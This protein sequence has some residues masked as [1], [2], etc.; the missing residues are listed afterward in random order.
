MNHTTSLNALGSYPAGRP[1]NADQITEF[2]AAR[3]LLL[4]YLC[5]K[6]NRIEGLT[7]L[8]K[9][10]F[11]VRYPDFYQRAKA[12]VEKEAPVMTTGEVDSAMVRHHYG[13]L[14]DPRVSG[15]Q[16]TDHGGAAG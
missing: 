6:R 2:H 9:L 16:G 5:G 1:L 4:L 13:P 11:F 8:A 10:D 3:I 15:E 14:P 12:H 7:K